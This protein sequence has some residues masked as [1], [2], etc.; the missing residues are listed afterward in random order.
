MTG[1][2]QWP[3][4]EPGA[5]PRTPEP[6]TPEEPTV[7]RRRSPLLAVVV[8][9]C[10]LG[11]AGAAGLALLG[12]EPD[13]PPAAGAGREPADVAVD[14]SV[15]G[16]AVRPPPGA[17]PAPV[18][19]DVLTARGYR[20]LLAALE[21]RTGSTEVFSVSLHA[22]GAHLEVPVD[23][24]TRREVRISWDGR[25]DGPGA[26]GTSVF[27]DRVDLADVDPAVFVRMGRQA[28][29]AVED[30]TVSH[31]IISGPPTSGP[32]DGTRVRVYAG[33]EYGEGGYLGATAGGSVTRRH[34]DR[35]VG[36]PR[37]TG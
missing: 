25:F 23:A 22:T 36:G 8:A 32:D 5:T 11:G 10:V 30:A 7:A 24:T 19:V 3:V 2:D 34:L 29:R 13:D 17:Q 6:R 27:H 1:E 15:D 31:V 28:L 35:P 18:P 33:N 21:R 12:G 20:A 37:P 26:T 16:P 4:Y 14:G 9:A